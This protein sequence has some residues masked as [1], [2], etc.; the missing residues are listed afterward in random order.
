MHPLTVEWVQKAE[1]DWSTMR[2]E[3]AVRQ[4]P[5]Y[6]AVCF[7]AQQCAEKYLKALLKENG[8]AVPKTH[9][10][11]A[12]LGMLVESYSELAVYADRMDSLS[13]LAVEVRYPGVVTDQQDAR[14]ALELAGQIRECIRSL[15]SLA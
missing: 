15:L 11:A 1:A 3:F 9:D 14:D 7:H 6:D 8:L 12:L 4:D 5:N 13:D 10:L 2:R